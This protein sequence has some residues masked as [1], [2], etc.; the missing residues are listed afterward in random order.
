MYEISQTTRI[1]GKESDVVY[2][3]HLIQSD[4]SNVTDIASVKISSE[5]WGKYT[6][7]IYIPEELKYA[8]FSDLR[9]YIAKCII[10]FI[11]LKIIYFKEYI[12]FTSKKEHSMIKLDI[13][14]EVICYKDKSDILTVDFSYILASV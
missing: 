12:D 1:T 6:E 9:D 2:R 3:I 8:S 5:C 10:G 11:E 7:K 4:F 14:D 13:F